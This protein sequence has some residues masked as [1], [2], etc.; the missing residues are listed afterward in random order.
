MT[1]FTFLAELSFKAIDL[2]RFLHEN[3]PTTLD[4][5]EYIYTLNTFYTQVIIYNKERASAEL[6]R[7]FIK[8]STLKQKLQV[9]YSLKIMKCDEQ[10]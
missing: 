3:V 2:I 4:K 10:A 5:S 7:C 9:R 8:Y 6:P 1:E